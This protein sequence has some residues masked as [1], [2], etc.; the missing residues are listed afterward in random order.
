MKLSKL[1]L[2]ALLLASLPLAAQVNDTYIIPAVASQ[3]GQNGT[4]WLTSFSLFNPY[5]FNHDLVISV[6][7]L[8]TGGKPGIEELVRVPSQSLAYSDDILFDLFGIENGSGSLLVATFAEDNP[9][10]PNDVAERAFMVTSNTYN[11][12]RSGTYGQTIPGVWL[13]MLDDG[14]RGA[15]HDVRNSAASKFRTNIGA[16]NLGRCNATLRV[17][18]HDA[19]GNWILKNAP[20]SLPPLGHFQDR[21]PVEV[22]AG[23]V[24]FW[25]EDPCRDNNDDYAVV[26]PY[27]STI[28]ELSGDPRYQTPMLLALAGDLFGKVQTQSVKTVDPLNVGKRIDSK[29][30]RGV[31]AEAEHRGFATLTRSAKGWK[32]T[33]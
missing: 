23:T 10:L 13:G 12:A 21:L 19:D 11:D 28:D 26:F 2:A 17:N 32:I 16:V 29:Y 5:S 8:P 6:T 3:G 7:Y 15:V 9:H 1:L 4:H 22:D 30:A 14:I 18:V 33:K 27:T 25:I 24:E 31:R 20:F